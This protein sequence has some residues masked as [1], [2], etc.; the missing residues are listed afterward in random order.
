MDAVRVTATQAAVETELAQHSLY[1][2]LLDWPDL[3]LH[4]AD[5][6]AAERKQKGSGV[7]LIVNRY[8]ER[9]TA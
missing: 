7:A 8:K 6:T 3:E 5:A 9:M 2:V 4:L 1:G